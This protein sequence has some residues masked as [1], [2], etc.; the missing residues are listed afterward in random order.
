MMVNFIMISTWAELQ[1]IRNTKDSEALEIILRRGRDDA[2]SLYAA[3]NPNCSSEAL[4]EVLR[5]GRNDWVSRHAANNPNCPS[6]A[7]SEV[8]RRGIKGGVKGVVSYF[9][10]MNP[11]CPPK[12]RIEWLEA[13]GKLT[14]YDP[15]RFELEHDN[16]D[17]DLEELKKLL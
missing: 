4:G 15:E 3:K 7:L 10:A 1:E 17:K 14:K 13:N 6:E 11:N 2:V 16:E 9:A 12:E 5:R 8:L